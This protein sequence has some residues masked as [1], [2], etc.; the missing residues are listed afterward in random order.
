MVNIINNI[1]DRFKIENEILDDK[2]LFSIFA[3]SQIFKN[4]NLD[5]VDIEESI[6]DGGGDG[7]IDSIVIFINGI[8][9][10]TIEELEDLKK[11]KNVSK[12]TRLDIN[13]LQIKD[14]V[15]YKESVWEK[16]L[17]TFMFFYDDDCKDIDIDLYPKAKDKFTL[18]K[19]CIDHIIVYSNFIT[20]R[21][22]YVNKGE[23]ENIS[24]GVQNKGKLLSQK[25]K[26]YT[27][28][29]NVN[30]EYFGANELR[31]IFNTPIDLSLEIKYE[32]ML[33]KS[34]KTD[35]DNSYVILVNIM[36]Y[37]RFITCDN[38]IREN[39][40]E[41]NIRHF[42]GGVEVNKEISNT[43]ENESDIDFWVMNNGITILAD[44][45]NP[46]TNKRLIL[47]NVQIINGL[48]TTYC[49]Y[50]YLKD[51]KEPS[52]NRAILIKIIKSENEITSD[53]IIKS[54]NSQTAIRP[55]ELRA[56][57][58][59]QRDIESNFLANDYYYERRKNYYK[60]LGKSQSK[61][62]SIAKTAQYVES[63]LF[64]N[65][66]AARNNPTSLL[67]KDSTYNK[68]FNGANNIDIY[69][70]CCLIYS[71]V[72]NTLKGIKRES[73]I[74]KEKYD[75]EL[76]IFY[77]HL[78]FIVS[79][80]MTNNSLSQDKLLRIEIDKIDKSICEKA[81]T[82]L[83]GVLA[84]IEEGN[85]INISKSKDLDNRIKDKLDNMFMEC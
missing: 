14:T 28:I 60:N 16:I 62:F 40:L 22:F 24:L 66:S 70:K 43:L 73:D 47:T 84:N 20:L 63:I 17:S 5:F 80:M 76:D 36:E 33:E 2:N 6:V 31:E 53:K 57:D 21:L 64:G 74:I 78:T 15:T 42:E 41:S 56:T 19:E 59:Y 49:I 75:V 10:T 34:F 26:K 58:Q 4:D 13:I 25:V 7:G 50:N 67:K 18:L 69:L 8:N 12:N 32:T 37:F 51:K 85:I 1:I 35:T 23:K 46:I 9:I 55:A 30:I 39:L 3:L 83:V 72:R 54:T 52:D 27:C 29:R 38:S 82:L 65:P 45:I 44:Q 68:I 11:T 61:I 71:K 81:L 79:K 48:Q 77:F